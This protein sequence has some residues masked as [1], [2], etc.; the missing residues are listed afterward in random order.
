VRDV[1]RVAVGVFE[2]IKNTPLGREKMRF[3]FDN[4]TDCF[5]LVYRPDDEASI[6]HFAEDETKSG[7]I[8]NRDACEEWPA[9]N[10]ESRSCTPGWLAPVGAA[11]T[12]GWSR[13]ASGGA[14]KS[15][16]SMSDGRRH[17]RFPDR[18]WED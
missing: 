6:V 16:D 7:P 11:A 4:R 1:P 15:N 8:G 2:L 12:R 13:Q 14:V 3:F 18:V 5:R 9:Y 10:D 17:P